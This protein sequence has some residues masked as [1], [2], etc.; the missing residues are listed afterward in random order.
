MMLD[1]VTG[2]RRL[3]GHLLHS[4]DRLLHPWRR[5]RAV[6]RVRT[7]LPVRSVCFVCLGNVNRSPYAAAALRRLLSGRPEGSVRVESAG[8]IG[9]GRPCPTLTREVAGEHGFDLLEHVSRL[10]TRQ[11]AD[12]A[13]LI[14][15]M[16]P[17]I[18]AELE[19]DFGQPASKLLV[20]GDLDP[21]AGWRREI[22]DP[23]DQ[24]RAV[25]EATFDRI[26]RCVMSL[27]WEMRP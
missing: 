16:S 27:M 13:E 4:P 1:L 12:A 9:P 7:A 10:L 6:V 26:D 19:T 23:Y 25:F 8:L 18:A 24:P 20:L 21:V 17:A 22:K 5:R 15:V 11:Q 3:A 2:G 14:A